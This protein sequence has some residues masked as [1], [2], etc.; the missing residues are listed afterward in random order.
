MALN[1]DNRDSMLNVNYENKQKAITG[2]STKVVY[3]IIWLP[4]K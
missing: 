1:M 4:D 2:L 3:Q